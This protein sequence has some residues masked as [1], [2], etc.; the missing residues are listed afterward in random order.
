MQHK[1][2][3]LALAASLLFL[4]PFKTFSQT[5]NLKGQ[6]ID[7]SVRFELIGATVRVAPSDNP[8]A[9]PVGAITDESGRFRLANL[10]L[11]KYTVLVTYLGYRNAVLTNVTL[12]SGKET[13]LLIELE[14][15]VLEQQEVVITA[16][17]DKEKPLNDLSLLSTRTFSV[18]E[19]RR[20]AA[21]VNDPAR[22]ATSYAGVVAADDGNNHIVIRGNAPNGLL[23]RMEGVDI[24]NPNH[25]SNVGT[26]GGGISILSS[27]LLTNS[28]FSTGAFA[29]EYGNALSGVFDLKLR[30]GN[31]DRREF[32]IQAGV[33]GLD[34]AAEGSFQA[35]RS[36]PAS[37]SAR[38]GSA[39][40]KATAG[41]GSYLVNYRYSTLSL[42]GKLG[43]PLGD[44]VT[45][46]QDLSFNLWRSS[47]KAGTFSL[48]G[49][50]G[51]SKQTLE[52]SPD[53]AI[54]SENLDKRYPYVFLANTGVIGMTHSKI[55]GSRTFLKTALVFSGTEN[56][57]DAKEYL[58]PDYKLR[59]N[60]ETSSR[61]T[62]GTLSTVLSHKFNARHFIRTGAYF[63]VLGFRLRQY[64]YDQESERLE[65]QLKQTGTSETVQAFA[66]WQYRPTDRVRFNLGV[67]S[68]TMLLN[69]K[70]SIEPRAALKYAPDAKQSFSLGYGL[71]SQVMP[72]GIYFVKN[73]EHQRLNPDLDLSKAHH[74]V[75][76]YDYF[77]RKK[78]HFKSELYYQHLFNV[79]VDKAAPNSFSM[80]NERDG[81]VFRSLGN[82][83]LGRNYGLEL[84][85]EQFLTRGLYWM[86]TLSLYRSEYRGSDLVWRNTRFDS[87]YAGSI[88]A[89]KEWG[90]NRRGKNRSFGLNL[91]LISTGGQL[92]TPIDIEASK[93]KNETVYVEDQAFADR[94]PAY[95]RLDTG[96][97][98]KRN[99]RRLT[100]TLTLDLQNAT[101]RQNIGGKFFNTDTQQ[102]EIWHQAPLIPVLAY[103]LE[104]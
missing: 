59:Q 12:D 31:S 45:N 40:K 88:T 57:L 71:H 49:L 24:P 30:K 55:W 79:P 4:C 58:L 87:R 99:Y 37:A 14:E 75:L 44:A 53:T 22:M 51:L 23:W 74:L 68:L 91:K 28:D 1:I 72:L 15:A 33:L 93:A 46:F 100:T 7:K 10:P 5:Q 98:L 76:A 80:L 81:I 86:A 96:V 21:A 69:N 90:W 64:R 62:K 56:G 8:E 16:T 38:Q 97:R 11:G 6:V 60:F 29:A 89:G 65:E 3:L 39:D 63:N 50:G 48:F 19:T 20:F 35:E 18:E 52:G 85:G 2:Y 13:D 47:G 34:V 83:G 9:V 77:P 61:Q 70:V 84:T 36:G 32:T 73:E 95:F 26:S 82:T 54:W 101:N 41:I 102:I 42:I 43:V 17:I 67:H 27:Q 78:L 92:D 66:Q 103:R 25:F 94:L 104:F